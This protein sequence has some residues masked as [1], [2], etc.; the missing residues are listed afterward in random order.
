MGNYSFNHVFP[1]KIIIPL[2]IS[3][4]LLN[5]YFISVAH[6][7]VFVYYILLLGGGGILLWKYREQLSNILLNWKLRPLIKFVLLGYSAVLTEE[8][9]VALVHALNS[10][11]SLTGWGQLILQFWAF[12]IFAFTGFIFGWYFLYR[13]YRY[14]S[15]NL[16]FIIG[17]WGLYAE[18][19]LS[20]L[21]TDFWGA[22]LL[23]LPT[24]SVYNLIIAPALASLPPAPDNRV[25]TWKK[26]L[27]S[28]IISFVFSLLPVIALT[29]LRAHWPLLFP[30]CAYIPC[31]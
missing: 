5:F 2:I 8:I 27:Y 9:L 13:R 31:S 18:K 19:T 30:P 16:F 15:A 11:A 28:F 26:C 7:I 3:V 17:L 23:I 12:N 25:K 4:L 20:Y 29:Y 21:R 6:Y 1:R 14:T 22:I 24:M 10:G